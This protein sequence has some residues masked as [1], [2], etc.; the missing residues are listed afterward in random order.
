MIVPSNTLPVWCS[1]GRFSM[2]DDVSKLFLQV[3]DRWAPDREGALKV[4][5][6]L[7]ETTLR[8]RDHLLESTGVIV[9]VEDVRTSLGWLV[10]AL[11]T[12]RL[13]DT[14]DRVRLGLLKIWL[15]E[16]RC[17]GGPGTPLH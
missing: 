5:D 4:L 12:G 1:P 13:P 9:T 3:A 8:Y 17:F 16:L 7:V 11:M 14:E 10:P 6:L 15:D 2:E